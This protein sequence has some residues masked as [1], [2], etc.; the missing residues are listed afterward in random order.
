MTRCTRRLWRAYA[1]GRPRRCPDDWTTRVDE[2][3]LSPARLVYAVREWRYF[4][5]PPKDAEGRDKRQRVDVR[6]WR[7]ALYHR[8]PYACDCAEAAH[9]W[10]AVPLRASVVPPIVGELLCRS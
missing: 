9:L 7:L 4:A 5:Y 8:R 2:P 3:L 10:P 1:S 6:F